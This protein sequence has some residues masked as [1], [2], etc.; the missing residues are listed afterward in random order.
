[1]Q[2]A[3]TFLLD[4]P[5]WILAILSPLGAM[6]WVWVQK[7]D[8]AG[9]ARLEA[10]PLLH[11]HPEA[12]AVLERGNTI[13]LGLLKAAAQTVATDATQA[14]AWN[15]ALAAKMAKDVLAQLKSELGVDGVAK[16]AAVS[17]GEIGLLG[18]FEGTG[19]AFISAP[20]P[21]MVAA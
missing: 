3:L 1:M 14:P 4:H 21:K 12:V 6:I 11:A 8:A 7:G 5:A 15:E 9:L 13:M 19:K 16:A 2:T 20:A 18:H 10:T 17:G